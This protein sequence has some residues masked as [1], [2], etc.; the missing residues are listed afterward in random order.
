MK[1]RLDANDQQ[2][3]EQVKKSLSADCQRGFRLPNIASATH[4]MTSNEGED[5]A[6]PDDN[7][8]D[9]GLLPPLTV[10]TALQKRLLQRQ[11]EMRVHARERLRM[12]VRR[13]TPFSTVPFEHGTFTNQQTLF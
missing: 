8:L 10:M 9:I 11:L 2:Y 6:H 1:A 4:C 12:A 7:R 5:A 13:F 3:I